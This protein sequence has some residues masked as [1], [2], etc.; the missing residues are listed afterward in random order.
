M[1]RALRALLPCLAAVPLVAIERGATDCSRAPRA[2]A[3]RRIVLFVC[4][5]NTCRRC[6]PLDH[7]TSARELGVSPL[8][9]TRPPPTARG[10]CSGHRLTRLSQPHGR[11]HRQTLVRSALRLRGGPAR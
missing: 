8:H 11:S 5:S 9:R 2:M 10:T 7:A 4:T 3:D 1:T 6:D